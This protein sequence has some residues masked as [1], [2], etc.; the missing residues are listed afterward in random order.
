MGSISARK[1]MQV[2]ENVEASLAIELL[3]AAQGIDQ[4]RPLRPSRGVVAAHAAIRRVS[5]ELVE[6]RALYR[7][8]AAVR[9]LLREGELIRAVEE[10]VGA[11]S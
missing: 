5:E 1:L 3:T 7:D 4:R 2:V 6:D 11:L 9:G 10:A 8:I